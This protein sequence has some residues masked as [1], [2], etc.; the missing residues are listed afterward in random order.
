M[1]E[2]VKVLKEQK[3]QH[4]D[5]QFII[6]VGEESGLVGA[7]ALDP[8]RIKAKYGFA[9][10]SDGDVGNIVVAAPTQAKI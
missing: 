10:D 2:A 8:T 6:T 3:F 7:K 5:I 9:L 4:G 1:L